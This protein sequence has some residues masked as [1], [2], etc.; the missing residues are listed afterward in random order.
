MANWELNRGADGQ[1]NP[2]GMLRKKTEYSS[3]E[4]AMAA[5]RKG[6]AAAEKKAEAERR[7][8]AANEKQKKDASGTTEAE[9]TLKNN[10]M[11]NVESKPESKPEAESHKFIQNTNAAVATAQPGD[12]IRTSKYPNGYQLTQ[13]DIDWAKRQQPKANPA[14]QDTPPVPPVPPAEN[15]QNNENR[16]NMQVEAAPENTDAQFDTDGNGELT[17]EELQAQ[18][19]E[20]KAKYTRAK[21]LYN[22]KKQA[23]K[24]EKFA[25]MPANPAQAQQNMGNGPATN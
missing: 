7:I 9:L 6:N 16:Y 14:P 12:W 24:K 15:P 5:A 18:M 10:P 13:A 2:A 3:A 4:E 21:A 11:S 23:Q 17:L 19:E 1:Y 25:N 22:Q 20:A 8:D